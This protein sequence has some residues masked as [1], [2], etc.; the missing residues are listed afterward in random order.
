MDLDW[1]LENRLPE[2]R[3]MAPIVLEPKDYGGRYLPQ[4]IL[5]RNLRPQRVVVQPKSWPPAE[6]PAHE[7]RVLRQI[8]GAIQESE[9]SFIY[10]EMEKEKARNAELQLFRSQLSTANEQ[11]Q[12]HI[13]EVAAL[14]AQ[15]EQ[16][17]AVL[18]Q[19]KLT[20]TLK[21]AALSNSNDALKRTRSNLQAALFWC[22]VLT[23]GSHPLRLAIENWFT[24]ATAPKAERMEGRKINYLDFI[25]SDAEDGKTP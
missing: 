7:A 6:A 22:V 15:L 9:T 16:T 23:V 5:D 1:W 24:E 4:N 13:N 3:W 20:L 17:S 21:K 2:G 12:A 19:N 8:E 10:Q 25:R 18:Q 14:N 11:L